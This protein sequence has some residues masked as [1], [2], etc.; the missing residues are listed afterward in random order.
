MQS[1]AVKLYMTV[2]AMNWDQFQL[3]AATGLAAYAG[4]KVVSPAR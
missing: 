3:S 2:S 4:A 1:N